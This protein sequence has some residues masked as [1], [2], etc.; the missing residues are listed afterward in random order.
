VWVINPSF[1][2]QTSILRR[3]VNIFFSVWRFVNIFCQFGVFFMKFFCAG[4]NDYHQ[5]QRLIVGI[6]TP[7]K[8]KS[9]MIACILKKSIPNLSITENNQNS[10][11]KRKKKQLLKGNRMHME[12]DFPF[13]HIFLGEG[14][15]G[16]V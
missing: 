4:V 6:S 12:G 13:F 3:F 10:G 14:N 8:Y 11:S 16:I 1:L 2:N 15:Q 5:S 9:T 7:H